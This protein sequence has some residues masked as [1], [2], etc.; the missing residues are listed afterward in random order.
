MIVTDGLLSVV[1]LL[2]SLLGALVTVP[3]GLPTR[4]RLRPSAC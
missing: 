3:G 1:T 4:V 2:L